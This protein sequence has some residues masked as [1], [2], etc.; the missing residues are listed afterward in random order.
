MGV[1][2]YF[3][4]ETERVGRG[5]L[6][7]LIKEIKAEREELFEAGDDVMK[8]Y[9]AIPVLEKLV[10]PGSQKVIELSEEL[11]SIRWEISRR[12]DVIAF[13]EERLADKEGK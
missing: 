2:R 3:E 7:G 10:A 6:R 9:N 11:A 1:D 4:A 12:D 8:E 5:V 13:L